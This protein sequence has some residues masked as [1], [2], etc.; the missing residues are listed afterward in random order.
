[1][2]DRAVYERWH[3]SVSP[4]GGVPGREECDFHCNFSLSERYW[5]TSQYHKETR[6]VPNPVSLP[7]GM[8]LCQPPNH[9]PHP[10]DQGVRIHPIGHG[11]RVHC[12]LASSETCYTAKHISAP[13]R[14]CN[15]GLLC[16]MASVFIAMLAYER[17]FAL[18]ENL[19]SISLH[20]IRVK[21]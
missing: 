18:Q 16:S 9:N 7:E 15:G 4:P 11:V 17:H 2:C 20:A 3:L 5:Q 10:I 19:R 14:T 13:F 8:C 6:L 12:T 21:A 1:M